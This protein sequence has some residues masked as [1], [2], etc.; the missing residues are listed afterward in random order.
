MFPVFTFSLSLT[1]PS[2]DDRFQITHNPKNGAE[3][4]VTVQ[5]KRAPDVQGWTRLHTRIFGDGDG[6]TVLSI[7]PSLFLLPLLPVKKHRVGYFLGYFWLKVQTP[8]KRRAA[9]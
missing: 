3:W 1:H 4:K 7:L 5:K 2:P 9:I 6:E 8:E